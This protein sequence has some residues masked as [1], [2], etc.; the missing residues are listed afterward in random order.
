M[1]FLVKVIY[2]INRICGKFSHLI[3]DNFQV[4][5]QAIDNIVTMDRGLDPQV[6][7]V[8]VNGGE[9][10]F[11]ISKR[12]LTSEQKYM[13]CVYNDILES[14]RINPD[15]GAS[16]PCM[17]S[18]I[19]NVVEAVDDS[20]RSDEIAENLEIEN[21][22]TGDAVE[23]E[24][25]YHDR[26]EGDGGMQEKGGRRGGQQYQMIGTHYHFYLSE[27]DVE[28]IT[29]GLL[30]VSTFLSICIERQASHREEFDDTGEDSDDD[31]TIYQ[32]R[33]L[34]RA[35]F[36][37]PTRDLTKPLAAY[38]KEMVEYVSSKY[39]PVLS[40][41]TLG[42]SDFV[43]LGYCSLTAQCYTSG[44]MFCSL[45]S[46]KSN[47]WEKVLD[48][49]NSFQS[50]VEFQ[51]MKKSEGIQL[52]VDRVYQTAKMKVAGEEKKTGNADTNPRINA[53]DFMILGNMQAQFFTELSNHQ[54]IQLNNIAGNLQS[55]IND[56][57]AKHDKAIKKLEKNVDKK[58][59][60][61][62][63]EVEALQKE[64]EEKIIQ[65][66]DKKMMETKEEM[67]KMMKDMAI[68]G[69][70][71]TADQLGKLET[72]VQ[73]YMKDDDGTSSKSSRSYASVASGGTSFPNV[74]STTSTDPDH[75]SHSENPLR[76]IF[77]K[78]YDESTR[79]ATFVCKEIPHFPAAQKL[80]PNID[81]RDEERR[82]YVKTLKEDVFKKYMKMSSSRANYFMTHIDWEST[83]PGF[84]WNSPPI[85][86]NTQ[87]YV[88]NEEGE[89]TPLRFYVR[90]DTITTLK[91]ME[92]DRFNITAGKAF[93]VAKYFPKFF[94]WKQTN[95]KEAGNRW[96]EARKKEGNYFAQARVNYEP[97]TMEIILETRVNKK[98]MGWMK[99]KDDE[100][101]LYESA[102]PE[103]N[104]H[105]ER[106]KI[107]E[108]DERIKQGM[109]ERGEIS[110]EDEYQSMRS[111]SRKRER[112]TIE[113]DDPMTEPTAEE[114]DEF[115]AV[116]VNN[117]KKK[118]TNPGKFTFVST[119]IAASQKIRNKSYRGPKGLLEVNLDE[120]KTNDMAVTNRVNKDYLTNRK[121]LVRNLKQRNVIENATFGCTWERKTEVE[122]LKIYRDILVDVETPLMF[123]S[124]HDFLMW[125]KF[126]TINVCST[127][128]VKIAGHWVDVDKNGTIKTI[129]VEFNSTDSAL[130]AFVHIYVS[131]SRIMIQSS[132]KLGD[133]GF[134]EWLLKA[135]FEKIFQNNIT[136]KGK[137]ILGVKAELDK[138]CLPKQKSWK[139]EE[140]DKLRKRQK[141]S[142]LSLSK[143]VSNGSVH[144]GDNSIGSNPKNSLRNVF[145]NITD[146][147]KHTP[148]KPTPET[149]TTT[150]AAEKL[151]DET[152]TSVARA[153]SPKPNIPAAKAVANIFSKPKV[154]PSIKP[155]VK[156]VI[157]SPQ[158]NAP[159]SLSP[160]SIST[161]NIEDVE[162]NDESQ[163]RVFVPTQNSTP[164]RKVTP[165]STWVADDTT[166]NEDTMKIEIPR[167]LVERFEK[168]WLEI[169]GPEKE[170]QVH[171]VGRRRKVG[172]VEIVTV[173]EMIVPAQTAN[174][175]YCELDNTEFLDKV[176]AGQLVGMLHVHCDSS[177]TYLSGPDLHTASRFNH[178][179]CPDKEFFSAVFDSTNRRVG[180][181][182]I[183]TSKRELIHK[184]TLLTDKYPNLHNHTECWCTVETK[185]MD[186]NV[187][188]TDVRNIAR[189]NAA[190]SKKMFP[191][192]PD[193]PMTRV[194]TQRSYEP[195][196]DMEILEYHGADVNE[197]ELAYLTDRGA[198]QPAS[199]ESFPIL[200]KQP[201]DLHDD[202]GALNVE[203]PIEEHL[204]AIQPGETKEGTL[205]QPRGAI[206]G[207]IDDEEENETDAE[208]IA[209]L[210]R[211]VQTLKISNHDLTRANK[212]LIEKKTVLDSMKPVADDDL[213]KMDASAVTNLISIVEKVVLN[214]M[215]RH[216]LG[217]YLKEFLHAIRDN[218]GDIEGFLMWGAK[219]F[220][221][222]KH[223]DSCSDLR[224]PVASGIFK[225][226]AKL[227]LRG[228]LASGGETCSKTGTLILSFNMDGH[229]KREVV[230]ELIE[231]VSPDFIA[232]QET[233][234]NVCSLPSFHCHFRDY[235][236]LSVTEDKDADINSINLFGDRLRGG[237]SL[238]WKKSI[239]FKVS[240]VK[241]N[242][243]NYVSVI[244]NTGSDSRCLLMSV[245][246][247]TASKDDD[248]VKVLS[249]IEDTIIAHRSEVTSIYLIGDLNISQKSSRERQNDFQAWLDRLSLLRLDPLEFTHVHKVHKTTNFLDGVVTDDPDPA[250][251]VKNLTEDSLQMSFR[252]DHR[253]I[254]F[255]IPTAPDE[256]VEEKRLNSEEYKGGRWKFRPDRVDIVN[257]EINRKWK[258]LDV[259]HPES[260]DARLKHMMISLVDTFSELM[261]KDPPRKWRK[262]VFGLKKER[263]LLEKLRTGKNLSVTDRVNIQIEIDTIRRRR[264]AMEINS[265]RNK[266]A[267]SKTDVFALVNKMK[268]Q[269]QGMPSKMIIGEEVFLGD[270]VVTGV[271]NYYQAQGNVDNPIFHEQFDSEE[272]EDCQRLVKAYMSS[273]EVADVNF[274]KVTM[275]EL[276]RVIHSYDNNTAADIRGVSHQH[277]KLL[278]EENLEIFLVWINSVLEQKNFSIPEL[279]LSRYC[280]LYK[281]KGSKVSIDSF[282]AIK[283]S[284]CT[285]RILQRV[286][287]RRG[288]DSWV[289]DTIVNVQSGFTKG[290]SFEFSL[291]HTIA[292]LTEYRNEGKSCV[293][294]T[295]DITKC[296]PR[297]SA[298]VLLNE[299][300][301]KG[302][303]PEDV[304]FFAKSC[305]G[306]SCVLKAGNKLYMEDRVHDDMGAKEGCVTASQQCK[307]I[308]N[309][310]AEPLEDS[311]FGVKEKAVRYLEEKKE[312]LIEER[313]RPLGL[314]ADDALLLEETTLGMASLLLAVKSSARTS[315]V[316]INKKKTFVLMWGNKAEEMKVEWEKL[317][318]E[319]M[320][321]IA[322]V[323]VVEYLGIKI[324]NSGNID[325]Q[326][327]RAKIESAGT[328]LRLIASCG[329][330]KRFLLPF[331]T[332]LNLMTS[333]VESKI[334]SALNSF[335]LSSASEK[336]LINFSDS[337]LKKILMAPEHSSMPALY[338]ISGVI[339]THLRW[340]CQCI[341]LFLR[342][343]AANTPVREHLR[344]QILNSERYKYNFGPQIIRILRAA[345]ISGGENLLMAGNVTS[346]N[347]RDIFKSIKRRMVETYTKKLVYQI[348]QFKR[349]PKLD[350]D[351]VVPGRG[352]WPYRW[353]GKTHDEL[354]GSNVCIWWTTNN[355]N[356]DRPGTV[357]YSDGCDRK[358]DDLEILLCPKNH[359]LRWI[360]IECINYLPRGNA[361]RHCAFTDPRWC[362][363]FSNPF[364]SQNGKNRIHPGFKYSERLLSLSKQAFYHGFNFRRESKRAFLE[365]QDSEPEKQQGFLKGRT[366]GTWT[367]KK[368]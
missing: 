73:S 362:T 324:T 84:W 192:E 196:T 307:L 250:L 340:R 137:E 215:S 13:D 176:D 101:S 228:D 197:T 224:G 85:D 186:F 109:L 318:Q 12:E 249:Q 96:V 125:T 252:S 49:L 40:N 368:V 89:K 242:S 234:L 194:L 347:Q 167:D 316:A 106:L 35:R 311:G 204:K 283:I 174:K 333:F 346:E 55:Q 222:F 310:I 269:A 149:G 235:S 6:K 304:V 328:N 52:S 345:D 111:K 11:N 57:G 161:E 216:T 241:V 337:A 292:L 327:V 331:N 1:L 302:A 290:K 115:V 32:R 272:L 156:K 185:V 198:A 146:H 119:G 39:R 113:E 182:K 130:K 355:F 263:D 61:Q 259:I 76:L 19:K 361:L 164:M 226:S 268:G 358:D 38:M 168:I 5:A 357:C 275:E 87:D 56:Q 62:Y 95:L 118:R 187:I 46:E 31:F 203:K 293:L 154:P 332:R 152:D 92:E 212:R 295:M 364:S 248:F 93:Y 288:F 97:T 90:F 319:G 105:H 107:K 257:L 117:L 123:V 356:V 294:A 44:D 37:I 237:V 129:K 236:F 195:L 284:S 279:H 151:E 280:I 177:G 190:P 213:G 162:E 238:A 45:V 267:Q 59:D 239:D 262:G 47:L 219:T 349:K 69:Q 223:C 193:Q 104:I 77:C 312:Y 209:R 199:A 211:L 220:D 64:S 27:E 301:C 17:I 155:T 116:M 258:E 335:T 171:L 266:I 334:L 157:K 102:I 260:L 63:T 183:K 99:K 353:E 10:V 230:Q 300:I 273:K 298:A 188:V 41:L 163:Q 148:D 286:I 338:L 321:D 339:P 29:R 103:L 94:K 309:I 33:H 4:F 169:M 245:Y 134:A 110:H 122:P 133:M 136:T 54:T 233:M 83:S 323:D 207:A 53:M 225:S 206:G 344:Y 265:I 128:V 308:Q 221:W 282:R 217:D 289:D 138:M 208:K 165:L 26:D 359:R 78:Q 205:T 135:I 58:L 253:P 303:N 351:M 88:V 126:Q 271:N 34:T 71:Q 336:M 158:I 201:G 287:L 132:N 147:R 229:S 79:S 8:T 367:K 23:T 159:Q 343:M 172:D 98:Y 9:Q 261:P 100:K 363:F 274:K 139:E 67:V 181:M 202:Y 86:H 191:F 244:Y 127:K 342:V 348:L 25:L 42:F 330:N 251:K 68:E 189:N 121:N 313:D 173:F 36:M 144:I 366:E 131:N 3:M 43:S 16:E 281:N 2:Q 227:N 72:S 329:L 114:E 153:I 184:C 178:T 277:L 70:K 247:P 21:D 256:N 50:G 124:L 315:R 285:I 325:E 179:F 65:L 278:S 365:K 51:T 214:G 91:T 66:M 170:M 306:R 305:L 28:K 232:L 108:V 317:M 22:G 80:D 360:K 18:P 291:L 14:T 24:P 276:R 75:P 320:T 264:R 180:F 82:Y 145:N 352:C 81:T 160:M 210:E 246:L 296:F 150:D 218:Q 74:S 48:L 350:L 112:H 231:K 314:V 326:V 140:R 7:C 30:S 322:V 341:S 143:N 299:M 15:S 141:G 166:G 297:I 240:P 254:L 142:K 20:V 270:Q 120:L 60:E 255:T 243:N 200:V 175:T 354:I